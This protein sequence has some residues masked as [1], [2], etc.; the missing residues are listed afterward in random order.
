MKSPH[1]R[2]RVRRTPVPV[3]QWR[4]LISSQLRTATADF[5]NLILSSFPSFTAAAG[6]PTPPTSSAGYVHFILDSVKQAWVPHGTTAIP[7]IFHIEE[8]G[9]LGD[10]ACSNAGEL[11]ELSFHLISASRAKASP[12]IY[13]RFYILSLDLNVPSSRLSDQLSSLKK[14]QEPGRMRTLMSLSYC[15]LPGRISRSHRC[16]C[17][18]TDSA[19]FSTNV[20]RISIVQRPC[21]GHKGQRIKG[22]SPVSPCQSLQ[23][24]LTSRTLLNSHDNPHGARAEAMLTS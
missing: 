14:I 17:I 15:H 18:S 3:H 1:W 5:H 20:N 22:S 19:S 24:A 4:V 2:A 23:T 8:M 13:C 7:S 16:K 11:S 10:K 12:W 6:A 9:A 21:T